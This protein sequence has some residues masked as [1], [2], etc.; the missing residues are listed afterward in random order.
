MAKKPTRKT[1]AAPAERRSKKVPPPGYN[2]HTVV[3]VLD[4]DLIAA[5]LAD[6][7]YKERV[8]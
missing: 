6:P 4:A 3:N 2:Y 7:E 5:K 1:T 8:Q